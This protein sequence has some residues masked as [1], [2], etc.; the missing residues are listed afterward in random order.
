MLKF[1]T[2]SKTQRWYPAADEEQAKGRTQK[3]SK[4]SNKATLTVGQYSNRLRSCSILGNYK[5]TM[6]AGKLVIKEN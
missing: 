3:Q 5:K 4:T 1:V 6:M 2:Q